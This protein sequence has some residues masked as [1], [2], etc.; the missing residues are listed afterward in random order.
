M[1]L[2]GCRKC[3]TSVAP[4]GKGDAVSRR[5]HM[6]IDPS[7]HKR[8]PT[9]WKTVFCYSTPLL[10]DTASGCKSRVL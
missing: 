2:V 10:P 6:L 5:V 9:V 8:S 1:C 7:T 4:K 3:S